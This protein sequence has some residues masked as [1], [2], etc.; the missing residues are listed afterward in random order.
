[1]AKLGN[2][3]YHSLLGHCRGVLLGTVNVQ[4][5]EEMAH[6]A[7]LFIWIGNASCVASVH[8]ITFSV[9]EQEMLLLAL[10][11]RNVRYCPIH[12]L[13]ECYKGFRLYSHEFV[14]IM[15]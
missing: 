12:S 3:T 11:D 1:M 4:I 7:S 9:G 10:V 14:V 5:C 6:C 8:Q 15:I 2:P 13:K